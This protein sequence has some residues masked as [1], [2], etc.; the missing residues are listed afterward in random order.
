MED[1]WEMNQVRDLLPQGRDR[2][3]F[4]DNERI[5]KRNA[6]YRVRLSKLHGNRDI[7]TLVLALR[8]GKS[9]SV[10]AASR[11]LEIK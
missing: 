9:M 2:I 7:L 5:P 10:L 1:R 11:C 8:R 3:N 6:S 4:L